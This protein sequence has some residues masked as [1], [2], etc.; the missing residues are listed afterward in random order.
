MILRPIPADA[1]RAA[2]LVSGEVDIVPLLPP[3][4]ADTLA[5]R[6]GIEIVKVQSH[7]IV[8]LGFDVRNGI[9]GNVDFRRAVDLSIDRQAITDKLLRGLGVPFGQIVA[10]VSF[11]YDPAIEPTGYDPD[12]ARELLE[13]SGYDNE[14]IILQY[15]NNNVASN[16]AVAQ[17]VAGFM[18]EV[19]INV[20]LQGMEY[21]A[22]FPL[23]VN[24]QL[25]SMHMFSYGPT[26]LDADLPLTSLYETGRTRGYWEDPKTD[27][28][29]RAQRAESDPKERQAL[30][31]EIWELTKNQA[32]YSMLYNETHV[33][34][35]SDR[36]SVEPRA[37]GIVRLGEIEIVK[38]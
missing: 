28:L 19:G 5:Q 11:G 34:G 17:A 10:P 12:K 1:S 2:A 31:S 36:V 27:E 15:P 18:R 21:T 8:Y 37:D 4:L 7:K 14:E 13:K 26:N 32:I 20:K 30:I 29:V 16:D 22:F 6:E 25:N 33:W 23:W 38:E 3:Q 24:R 9:L 35:I